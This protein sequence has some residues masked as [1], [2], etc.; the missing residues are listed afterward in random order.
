MALNSTT[1][2]MLAEHMTTVDAI[3]PDFSLGYIFYK[4]TVLSNYSLLQYAAYN[5]TCIRFPQTHMFFTDGVIF[6]PP[7]VLYKTQCDIW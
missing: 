5:R 1:V 7:A 2:T 6:G 3:S 4:I